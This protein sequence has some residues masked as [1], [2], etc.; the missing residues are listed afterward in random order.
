MFRISLFALVL[1]AGACSSSENSPG[2]ADS[3]APAANASAAQLKAGDIVIMP[4]EDG[5]WNVGKILVVDDFAVHLR[6]FSNCYKKKPASIPFSDLTMGSG[7]KKDSLDAHMSI[8]HAPISLEG[9]LAAKPEVIGNQ[10]V[11]ESELEGYKI[12][13]D[14]F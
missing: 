8:G 9:F 4:N 7:G 2:L 14:G 13:R 10:P 11:Q 6:S 12:W 5:T 1:A 3:A